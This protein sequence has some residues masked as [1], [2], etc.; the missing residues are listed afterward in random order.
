MM[1]G[2]LQR[3]VGR[4]DAALRHAAPLSRLARPEQEGRSLEPVSRS[5]LLFGATG[6]HGPLAES[7]GFLAPRFARGPAG[8]SCGGADADTGAPASAGESPNVKDHNDELAS[9]GCSGE[10]VLK[11]TAAIEVAS[12]PLPVKGDS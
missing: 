1:Q 11:G 6:R 12:S 3:L 7:T 10:S 5:W 9:E 2:L 4:Y 8:R